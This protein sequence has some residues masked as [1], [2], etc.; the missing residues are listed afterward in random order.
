MDKQQ[1]TKIPALND[2]GKFIYDDEGNI[3]F[4]DVGIDSR[5]EGRKAIVDH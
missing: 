3:K 1:R 4:F 5:G 2:E